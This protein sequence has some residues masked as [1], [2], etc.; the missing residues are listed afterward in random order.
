[1]KRIISITFCFASSIIPSAAKMQSVHS[2]SF[3][4]SKAFTLLGRSRAGDGTTF[5]IPELRWMFDCG[6]L[7]EGGGLRQP[8]IIWMTHTHSDHVFTLAHFT[9]RRELEGQNNGQPMQVYLPS[10]AVPFVDSYLKSY[11]EMVAMEKQNVDNPPKPL[12]ELIG[13]NPNQEI[14]VHHGG[15][16]FLVRVV[17][18]VHRVDCVGYSIFE[19]RRKLKDEY[20]GMQGREV[21]QL[22]KQGVNIYTESF[23]PLACYLGDTTAQVFCKHP[24][25]LQQHSVVVVE[26]SFLDEASQDNAVKTMHMHWKDLKPLVEAHPETLFVLT[27]FSL[28]YSVSHLRDF[29]NGQTTN[30]LHP[31]IIE[32]ELQEEWNARKLKQTSIMNTAPNP[33]GC[34]CFV[35]KSAT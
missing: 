22:K 27:H 34:R 3:S 30:N 15:K 7:V 9:H 31:M 6:A 2:S 14:S 17:E 21:G 10:E 19:R 11:A 35:C 32:Q 13:V 28:K 12:Y 4:L 5:V 16:E 26:C 8:R 29:F 23:H 20:V 1:M 18:C 24:E 25:I 33:P